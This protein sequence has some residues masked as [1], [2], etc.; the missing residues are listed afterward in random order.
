M[1]T[2]PVNH[3]AL[4]FKQSSPCP[5]AVLQFIDDT[6][7]YLSAWKGKQGPW[8]RPS[9]LETMPAPFDFGSAHR[10]RDRSGAGLFPVLKMFIFPKMDV[11]QP[12]KTAYFNNYTT[13]Y[14]Y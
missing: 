12:R 2:S 8:L 3:A 6:T 10:H 14:Y 13:L 1:I 11:N 9:I 5:I 7:I 4:P